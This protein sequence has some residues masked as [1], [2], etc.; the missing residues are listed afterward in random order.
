MNYLWVVMPVYNEEEC[1]ARVIQEWLKELRRYQF[2]F[3]LC[4]INDGS[5][6]NTPLILKELA[7]SE[8]ELFI[9]NKKNTGHGQ[10]C[11]EGYKLG[12]DHQA[13][14]IFQIDSDGQCDPRFFK[15][16]LIES[17]MYPI[18]YG[19]RKTREDGFKR[20][21]ISHIIPVFIFIRTGVYVRDPNVPYRL[22][23]SYT[24]KNIINKVPPDLYLVNILIAVLQKKSYDIKWVNIHFRNRFGGQST[25]KNI[26]FI[27]QGFNFFTHLKLVK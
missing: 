16:V 21:Y 19:F 27:K 9:V 15:E 24:L 25:V 22:M 2:K 23:K 5:N 7:G 20:S 1:I 10:S 8:K 3:T 14:W 12:L 13:E 6:D 4:V 11:L 18:V 26:T 17:E